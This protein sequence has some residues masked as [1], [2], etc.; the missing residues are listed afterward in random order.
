MMMKKANLLISLSVF[1][2]VVFS[3]KNS[4][5]NLGP[6]LPHY[7]E[8]AIP[9]WLSTIP[10]GLGVN[11]PGADAGYVRTADEAGLKFIRMDFVWSSVEQQRGVY[12][13]DRYDAQI[14]EAAN[15]N[16]GIIYIL[17]Y[18]NSLYCSAQSVQT[19]AERNAFANFASAAA[20][21]YAGK[22]IFWEIWNE[23]NGNF[24]SPQPSDDA[25][26]KLVAVTAPRIRAADPTAIILGAAMATFTWPWIENCFKKGLL[27]YIDAVTVH[28]YRTGVPET[29]ISDYER[30]RGL[31][32]TYSP[33]RD[34]P[35]ISGEWGYSLI[36]WGGGPKITEEQQASYLARMFLVNIYQKIPL[37]IWYCIYNGPEPEVYSEAGYGLIKWDGTKKASYYAAQTICKRLEGYTYIERIN[38][39]SVNDYVLKLKKGQ[40]EALAMWT[41]GGIHN[42]TIPMGAG[43]KTLVQMLGSETTISWGSSGLTIVISQNPQYL[44]GGP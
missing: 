23:P 31:I 24:W 11:V 27:D 21:R 10:R 7:T 30:L 33:G 25:Y 4:S 8:T 15:R 14:Q 42:I 28:P 6:A 37:S 1:I 17:D 35:I 32:N 16:V 44:G 40:D 34:I 13:F 3:C 9:A 5:D 20:A 29:V 26:T 2:L 18:Q 38:V 12:N 39:G 43:T 41:V 19:D 22:K 36:P